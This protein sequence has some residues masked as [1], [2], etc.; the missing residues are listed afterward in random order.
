[1][2]DK[3]KY[4]LIIFDLDDTLFDYEKTERKALKMA[5]EYFG[6]SYTENIYHLYKTI[7]KNV[8]KS[9]QILVNQDDFTKFRVERASVFLSSLQKQ[10]DINPSDFS[11]KQL[12]FS[13]KGVLINSVYKT[14]KAID[15][16]IIKI[17]A[18]NGTNY[19]RKNKIE[20]SRIRTYID[21]F[22]SSEDLG[23]QKPDSQFIEKII[24]C[25]SIDKENI[26]IVGDNLE[27][28]IQGALNIGIDSCLFNFRK[29]HLPSSLQKTVKVI[30]LFSDLLHILN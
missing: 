13:T 29:K 25:Y 9:H 12:E 20:N 8:H 22:Y 21:G 30:N 23:V 19:P 18:T 6:L 16:S 17:I 27:T 1:M 28:D 5:C 14:L 11:A 26:L 2:V 4:K 7:N 3:T 24:S 10:N 15:K